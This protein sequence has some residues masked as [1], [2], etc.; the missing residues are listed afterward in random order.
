MDFS[1]EN[2][3]FLTD[4]A[5]I[6]SMFNT[7]KLIKF[8]HHSNELFYQYVNFICS[9]LLASCHYVLYK[10]KMLQKTKIRNLNILEMLQLKYLKH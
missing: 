9:F 6:N 2:E 1:V 3:I 5:V 7:I 10:I 4:L 8:Y